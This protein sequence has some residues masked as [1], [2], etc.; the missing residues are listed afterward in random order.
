MYFQYQT[1]GL[2]DNMI[3][4]TILNYT[5]LLILYSL[6]AA[7]GMKKIPTRYLVTFVFLMIWMR[8]AIAP[9]IG[10]SLY[11]NWVNER[12]QYYISRLSHEVDRENHTLNQFINTNKLMG[13]SDVLLTT[14]LKSRIYHYKQQLLQ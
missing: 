12:Q 13:K 11:T 1:S 4:P 7:F 3:L 9:V 8:N 10:S 5:G 14:T 2:F 6:I